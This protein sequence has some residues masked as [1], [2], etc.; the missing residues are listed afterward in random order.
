M[1]W[2]EIYEEFCK[3][4][5]TRAAMVL[6][7]RPWGTNSIIVWLSNGMMYKVKRYDD[8]KFVMQSVLEDDVKRKFGLI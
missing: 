5:P 6:D 7:Y 4:S 3:W 1:T 8:G 2:G